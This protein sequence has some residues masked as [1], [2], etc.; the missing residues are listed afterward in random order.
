MSIQ[1]YAFSKSGSMFL[2]RLFKNLSQINDLAFYSINSRDESENLLSYNKNITKRKIICP[3]RS[4]PGIK[5]LNGEIC[6]IPPQEICEYN[7][8][9]QYI[10]HS[11]NPIDSL[12]SE[13]YSFGF[14]HP[15]S[16]KMRKSISSKTIDEYCSD[17]VN[18]ARL[19]ENYK[20]LIDWILKY[21]N[22]QNVFISNYDDMYYNFKTWINNICGFLKLQGIDTIIKTFAHEF[23]NAKN[24]VYDKTISKKIIMGEIKPHH[25]SGLSNQYLYELKKETI[26]KIKNMLLDKITDFYF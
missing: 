22:K 16:P 25:R 11:R 19:N 10:I 21:G 3:I 13:Y 20:L 14:T 7:E 4:V 24:N 17:P 23:S 5:E 12:I 18:I 1:V 2:Y 9:N 15:G 8:L 26:E 6:Q